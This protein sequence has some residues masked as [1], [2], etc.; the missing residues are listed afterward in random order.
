MHYPIYE[1]LSTP[2]QLCLYVDFR[3]PLID[4]YMRLLAP[5]TTALSLV[6]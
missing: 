1:T 2:L 3:I 5:Y 4:T 6:T